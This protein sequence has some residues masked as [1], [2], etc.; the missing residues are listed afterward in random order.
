MSTA[1]PGRA[2]PVSLTEPAPILDFGPAKATASG[3]MVIVPVA[4]CTLA[5]SVSL[6]TEDQVVAR[7]GAVIVAVTVTLPAVAPAVKVALKSPLAFVAPGAART[8]SV[9]SSGVGPTLTPG[10]GLPKA[11]T[12]LPETTVVEFGIPEA[13]FS[14][15][16]YCWLAAWTSTTSLTVTDL[17]SL[18]AVTVAAPGLVKT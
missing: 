12:T 5:G 16:L 14:V 13:L 15:M 1:A 8:P 11:S 9:T 3:A 2:V 10:T 17:P 7:V 18:V 6:P 4:V